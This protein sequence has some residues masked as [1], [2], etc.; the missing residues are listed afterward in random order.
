MMNGFQYMVQIICCMLNLGFSFALWLRKNFWTGSC[1]TVLLAFLPGV[2]AVQDQ[3]PFPDIKFKTFS[4]F[5]KK[6][7]SKEVSL[8]TAL[9]FLFTTTNNPDLFNLHARQ[10]N[11][12]HADEKVQTISGWLKALARALN[13]RLGSHADELF[14]SE[15]TETVEN[16]VEVITAIGKKL[17]GLSKV[18]KL[19]PYDPN[20]RRQKTKLKPISEKAIDPAYVIC[21]MSMEC[22]TGSCNGRSILL[23][24][25]DRDTPRVSLVKGTKM[26]EGAHVLSDHCTKCQTIFYADHESSPNPP[27]SEHSKS[28]FYLNDAKYIKAGQAL[29]VDRRF[30]AA[31]INGTYSFHASS[32]A[33]AEF[34]NDSFWGTQDTTCRKVSR[35]QI[36]HIF[37]QESVR[38]VAKSSGKTLKLPDNLPIHEVTKNAFSELGANGKILSAQGH[39]CPE[40]T[41]PYKATADR[42]TGDDPAGILG[43]DEDRNVPALTE[44]A[45]AAAQEAVQNVAYARRDAGNAEDRDTDMI[46]QSSSSDSGDST[47]EGNPPPT[48]H[49]ETSTVKM[50]V[51]DG[52]V[53]GPTVSW[54]NSVLKV[55]Y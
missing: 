18:L 27:N 40:C 55:S 47:S 44:G 35:R 8:A 45:A 52:I 23:K 10:Q 12:R 41:Q 21:P 39:T 13:E 31:V 19:Y 36:W 51:M 38:R 4:K 9:M 43:V 28:C 22:T 53:M 16:E 50:V 17:D 6:N 34:W 33:Y 54:P 30:S 1:I 20:T 37:V 14:Q 25:R 26:Y 5:V 48:E 15:D 7:F 2:S 42:I 3:D 11:P 46:S 29:W 32:S 49:A 24:S